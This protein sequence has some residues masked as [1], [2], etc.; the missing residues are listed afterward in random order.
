MSAAA[1]MAPSHAS[2]ARFVLVGSAPQLSPAAVRL[3]RLPASRPISLDVVLR[4]RDPAGLASFVSAVATPA[5]PEFR[6]YLRPGAFGARFG[7]TAATVRSAVASLQALGLHVG[8]VSG[9]HLVIKVSSTVAV[10]ERAFGTALEQYRL[11]SGEVVYANATAPRV[12]ARLGDE[13]QVIAGLNDLSPAR[14]MVLVPA[15]RTLPMPTGRKSGVTGVPG[16]PQ[17]CAAASNGTSSSGGPYSADEVASAY[18]LSGL[19]AAGDLGAGQTVAVVELEPFDATNVRTYDECYFGAAQGAAMAQPPHLNVIDVNGKLPGATSNEDVESTLD[20]EEISGFV[21]AATIDVYESP[22]TTAGSIDV[23]NAIFSQDLAKVVSSSWGTCEAQAGG[24][25]LLA[26]EANLFE[27]AAAQGQTFVAASGDDGSSDCTDPSG[28]PLANTAVDDPASQPYVTGVGGSTLES[29]GAP[30][31]AATAA[32]P[33]K[34]TAWNSDG[35][36]GGGGISSVWAMPGYQLH[37]QPALQVVK[38]Y[39]SRIPCGEPAGFCREVPDVSANADPNTGL[40]IN[41]SGAGGNG[42]GALGGTSIASPLWAALVALADALPACGGRP[43]GFLNPSLY[44]LAGLGPAVYASAFNDVRRGNNHLPQFPKWWQYGASVGFDPVTGLGTP[45]A[46]NAAGEGLV[47]QLCALPESGGALYASPTRSSITAV[48]PRVKAKRSASS[49]I[50]VTLRTALG[51]P[52]RAKRVILVGTVTSPIKAKTRI[53]PVFV[54]T[55]AKGVAVFQVSDTLVQKVTYS[56][57]DLT[58]GIVLK[59]S[60][61]VSYVKS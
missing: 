38:P 46:T 26:A 11:V 42:W 18:G 60:A 50:K 16:G 58:D 35:V 52:I 40:M 4:P 44:W 7:A 25:A 13:I 54:T 17:P 28:Y 32:V 20:V 36:A 43:I 51:L 47:A 10:A 53:E 31:A 9:N 2:A 55:N 24:S 1:A 27:E 49:W 12:P 8:A 15:R 3:G 59:G 34:E 19:Y 37:S 6:R 61:T 30:G 22:N 23:Y 39:S 14:P 33:P 29:L 21:P 48:L 5:S 41:W 57:T 45:I 56:A